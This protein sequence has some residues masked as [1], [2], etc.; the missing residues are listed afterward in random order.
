MLVETKNMV[1]SSQFRARLPAY[2]AA[3]RAQ[4]EPVCVTH[5]GIVA[6]FF[7]GPE[8]YERLLGMAVGELLETRK[9]DRRVP[10]ARAMARAE[11]ALAAAKRTRKKRP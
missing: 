9:H 7:I 10:H 4:G 11:A 1:P 3:A 2:L 6:G 5:N 8:D